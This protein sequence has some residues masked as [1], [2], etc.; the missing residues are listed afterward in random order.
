MCY[1]P[2][3]FNVRS[4]VKIHHIRHKSSPL[5]PVL[6]LLKTVNINPLKTKRVCFMTQ[7]VPR[8]KH[9][10]PWLYKTSL[11]MMCK[12]KFAVSSE[13]RAKHINAM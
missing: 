5:D 6:S 2:Y 9:S 7:C 4:C 11:L 1:K 8:C 13:I 3:G 12:K 10:A